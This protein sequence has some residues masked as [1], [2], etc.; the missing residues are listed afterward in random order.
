MNTIVTAII[1]V[2]VI[3]AACAFVLS[4]ASKFMAVKVDER[5][6]KL[7]ECLPGSNCGA[8]GYPGC[9]GYA[10]A[11]NTEPDIKM[12]L[13]APG[14]AETLKKISA[15]LGGDAD[16][17]MEMDV[18]AAVVHCR[19]SLSVQQKKMEYKG[20]K[21]CAAASRIFGGE[22]GCAFGC[23]GYGDCQAV[24][25]SGAVCIEDGLAN[26]NQNCT[27]CGLCVKACPNKLIS[28][29]NKTLSSVVLCKNLEKGAAVRKKCSMG[30]IACGKCVRECQYG[31]ITIVDNLAKIDYD[32]C[33]DCGH[34]A[35]TC[36]TKCIT[37]YRA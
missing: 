20:I 23:L 33:M 4:L 21:T 9:A 35:E 25:P 12:N 13:C 5:A 6:A 27:A 7:L 15:I 10:E 16:A 29:E 22:R 30:C 14:G 28:I 24:C 36:V 37:L 3:G 18:R 26:I 11:L 31:A 2:A 19:G 1:S 17:D 8:C 34:C 32:K